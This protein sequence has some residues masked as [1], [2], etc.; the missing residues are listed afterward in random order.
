VP[1]EELVPGDIV[2][3]EPGDRVPADLRLVRARNLLIDEALLTGESAPVARDVGEIALAGSV[4][5]ERGARLRVVRTGSDTR[6]SELARLV[7]QAQAGRPALARVADRIAGG[8]VAALLASAVLVF[9]WWH[10]HDPTRALEVTLALLVVSCPCALSLAIP[11]ATTTAHGALA[12]IGVLALRADA[13]S[14]LARVDHVVFDKTGTLGTGAVELVSAEALD[15]TSGEAALAVAAALE[16]GSRHPLSRAFATVAVPS[17]VSEVHHL[18]GSGLEGIVDGRRWR[19]G[20][21]E[22]A[23]GRDDDTALWLGDGTHAVARFVVREAPRPD[24]RAA[25]DALAAQGIGVELC[26]GDASE[27]VA[28]FAHSVGITATSARQS[29]EHKLA[30][31][32]ALQARGHVVAMVGDG[33]NDAPVLAGA[34]VSLAMADGAALAQRAAAL[35]VTGPSLLRIPQAIALARRTRSV[36]RQNLAWALG[37]NLLALPLAAT[38]HVTPW[39]AALGMALSSLLVTGNALRLARAPGMAEPS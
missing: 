9:W 6:L 32:R 1:A 31:V 18:P 4:C 38:G 29:P 13:L 22:F 10:Q 5:R 15:G 14:V 33:I 36:V 17:P 11:A 8:F 3:I 7:E 34:D 30:R 37:Y 2:L 35:V 26:S 24:A 16:T 23:G 27:T 12:R 19:L 21:A 20:R 25:V 39:A 28:R